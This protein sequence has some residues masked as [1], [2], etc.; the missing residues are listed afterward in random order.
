MAAVLRVAVGW[1]VTWQVLPKPG[2]RRGAQVRAVLQPAALLLSAWPGAALPLPGL[3]RAALPLPG[4]PGAALP[5]PG[6]SRAALP[7]PGW[8]GAA[9]PSPAQSSAA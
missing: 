7:L 5:L 1:P 6:L 2:R 4:W 3:S 8:P 9:L